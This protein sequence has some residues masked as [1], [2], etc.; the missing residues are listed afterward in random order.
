MSPPRGVPS[1]PRLPRGVPSPLPRGVSPGL[2]LGDRE[3]VRRLPDNISSRFRRRSSRRCAGVFTTIFS[4]SSELSRFG[5][6]VRSSARN[7]RSW[8]SPR[9]GP[10]QSSCAVERDPADPGLLMFTALPG[11]HSL[12]EASSSDSAG[13]A[14]S[15]SPCPDSLLVFFSTGR[16]RSVSRP[17]TNLDFGNEA[18]V[19]F[20]VSV[21]CVSP[22]ELLPSSARDAGRAALSTSTSRSFTLS[23]RG[24]G[25]PASSSSASYLDSFSARAA[26]RRVLYVADLG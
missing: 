24:A 17:L 21:F 13:D 26:G 20:F 7:V 1:P 4:Y 6:G 18:A 3:R 9:V 22:W 12:S 19:V 15:C 14:P 10:P 2:R 23:A 8:S 16:M 11:R 5:S 25:R